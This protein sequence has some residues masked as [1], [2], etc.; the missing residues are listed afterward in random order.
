MCSW[1]LGRAAPS[2]GSILCSLPTSWRFGSVSLGKVIFC[3]SRCICVGDAS[4][5]PY[6]GVLGQAAWV[7]CPLHA[8]QPVTLGK[9]PHLEA[10]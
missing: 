3:H 1:L 2:P 9:L 4:T 5:C 6:M 10:T 8:E 7:E